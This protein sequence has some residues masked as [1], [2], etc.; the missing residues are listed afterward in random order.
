MPSEG[1]EAKAKAK[2]NS[3][4][5]ATEEKKTKDA[6]TKAKTNEAKELRN[7]ITGSISDA[8]AA[9]MPALK[10]KFGGNKGPRQDTTRTNTSGGGKG[11][12][13]PFIAD[14]HP[15]TAETDIYNKMLERRADVNGTAVE[16]CLKGM[17]GPGGGCQYEKCKRH[18][19]KADFDF[20]ASE[21]KNIQVELARRAKHIAHA[22]AERAKL[23]DA[24]G[25]G[26]GAGRGTGNN[27]GKKGGKAKGK[28]TSAIPCAF[29]ARGTCTAGDACRYKHG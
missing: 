17:F 19:N 6:V 28:D 16:P 25:S 18:H 2:A 5:K 29:H 9:A 11:K 23:P 20:T 26:A 14:K 21:I 4:A 1:K 15:K 8:F 24:A 27:G 7:A 13:K 3:K 10:G 22:V 12:G